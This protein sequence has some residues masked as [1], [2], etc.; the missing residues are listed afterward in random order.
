MSSEDAHQAVATRET[1]LLVTL[2]VH[3]H[4][5]LIPIIGDS[6]EFFAKAGDHVTYFVPAALVAGHRDLKRTLRWV[7]TL[8]HSVGCHGLSH[9]DSEDLA[10]LSASGE[11]DV[12]RRATSVL[13]DALGGPVTSFRAPGFRIGRRTLRFLSELGYQADLSVTPQRFSLTSS[14][15]YTIG[16]WWAPRAPYRP[17][18][19]SPF[20]RGDLT[21]LELP[22][23]SL[24]LPLA[25]GTIANLPL[26]LTR[27]LTA[28]LSLEARYFTRALVPM[29]HPEAVVGECEPWRPAFPAWREF[30][31]SRYGGIRA[32]FYFLLE[33][34]P[35]AIQRRTLAILQQLREIEGLQSVSVDDYLRTLPVVGP[36][37]APGIA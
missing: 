33:R 26:W 22:T 1:P 3:R 15:P 20:R 34:N 25:H 29:F 19:S 12:L 30:V 21:V 31:P 7:Q 14:S 36:Q 17:S 2:D 35:E 24:C 32:R 5:R 18:V 4:P 11:F 23:S 6:A 10:R 27:A 28:V 9:D 37:V 16:W 13:S 8:G